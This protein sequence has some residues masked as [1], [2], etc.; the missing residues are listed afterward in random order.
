MGD[1]G[2]QTN[3]TEN[4]S[5][6]APDFAFALQVSDVVDVAK[7]YASLAGNQGIKATG[8][9]QTAVHR[10]R[11]QSDVVPL[12]GRRSSG[13]ISG[14]LIAAVLHVRQV[15]TNLTPAWAAD[16]IQDGWF[17]L[18][19]SGLT[20]STTLRSMQASAPTVTIRS[21]NEKYLLWSIPGFVYRTTLTTGDTVEVATDV[22][23]FT[24]RNLSLIHPAYLYSLDETS[25]D[26]G[27]AG[28]F[29]VDI[30]STPLPTTDLPVT[31]SLVKWDALNPFDDLKHV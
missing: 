31:G 26:E 23:K 16:A 7:E 19:G 10:W 11:I 17:L 5:L 21:F 2:F 27:I 22:T 9:Q 25:D 15:P 12:T 24:G 28:H 13:P 3:P 20:I 6:Y 18:R 30:E 29:F 14:N 1:L 4:P 8:T